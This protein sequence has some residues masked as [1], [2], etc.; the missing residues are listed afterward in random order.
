MN[1]IDAIKEVEKFSSIILTIGEPLEGTVIANFEVKYNLNL[2]KDY[3]ILLEKHNGINLYGIEI[4]G[5]IQNQNAGLTSLEETYLFEHYEVE[6]VMPFY[7]IPF[8][9][10]GG[11]NH[12]CFD[13]RFNNDTSCPVVFWQHDYLYSDEKT[14]T[15]QGYTIKRTWTLVNRSNIGSIL[16]FTIEA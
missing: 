5:I 11:G 15:T 9:P 1:I 14:N 3:K 7:L 12:Y 13:T 8:S 6:N 10:D 2:P 16:P 4:Y